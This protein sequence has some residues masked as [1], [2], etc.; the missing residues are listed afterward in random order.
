MY[1]F[2]YVPVI[3]RIA[4]TIALNRV[5]PLSAE[6]S[7]RRELVR[8]RGGPLQRRVATLPCGTVAFL[9]SRQLRRGKT[10]AFLRRI[11]HIRLHLP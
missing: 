1:I 9:L 2:V 10:G 4:C 8:A 3:G 6:L 7:S 5:G 11:A